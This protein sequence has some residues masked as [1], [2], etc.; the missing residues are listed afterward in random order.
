MTLQFFT[1]AFSIFVMDKR[2]ERGR[3]INEC[4]IWK[5]TKKFDRIGSEIVNFDEKHTRSLC[6]KVVVEESLLRVK[7][8]MKLRRESSS[9]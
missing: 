7:K 4:G 6:W 2:K 8:K 9:S 1:I 3:K 5:M